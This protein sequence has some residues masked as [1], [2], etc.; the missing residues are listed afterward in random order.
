MTYP[1]CKEIH[2][3]N[4]I[5]HIIPISRLKFGCN[6]SRVYNGL[7]QNPRDFKQSF[8]FIMFQQINFYCQFLEKSTLHIDCV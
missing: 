2:I 7:S 6:Y 4:E 8:K 1:L 5:Y 3:Y